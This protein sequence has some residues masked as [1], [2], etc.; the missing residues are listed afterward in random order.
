[1]STDHDPD[2]LISHPIADLLKIERREQLVPNLFFAKGVTTIVAPSG[3]GKTTTVFSAG[4]YAAIGLWG[5]ELI[6]K[7]PLFWIAGEDQAGLRAIYEA[8]VAHNPNRHPDARFMEEAVDFSNKTEVNKLIKHLDGTTRPLIVADALADILGDLNED[9]SQDINRV[10]RNVWRVVHAHDASFGLLHHSGWEEKRERGSTAIRAK[11]DIL[12]QIVSFDPEK[13]LVELKHHKLRG[14]APLKQFYLSVKLVP[15]GG[16]PQPIPIVTGP[17]SELEVILSEP[18]DADDRNAR[19]LVEIMLVGHF[20]EGATFTKLHKQSEM[21]KTTF[22]SALEC[23]KA[24]GWIVG[25]GKRGA[26]YNLNPDGSWKI[27]A[28]RSAQ[29]SDLV[30]PSAIPLRD[31]GPTGPI[32]VGSAGRSSD[33]VRTNGPNT[34]CKNA[35]TTG[36][37]EKPNQIIETESSIAA[38]KASLEE[39]KKIL[40]K[41]IER[42]AA[43][44]DTTAQAALERSKGDSLLAMTS[45]AIQH[46]DKKRR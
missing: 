2:K 24:K 31:S 7:R 3:A 35:D 6:K 36:S 25:G 15:V 37:A 11:S 20:P 38:R 45:E 18:L 34:D 8:W 30:G 46:A 40:R 28:E 16:Y 27:S 12:V 23:A 9:K 19:K 32:N 43:A 39:T 41:I 22:C 26:R 10:Y 4:L 17:K 1:M 44:D 33:H 21:K 13:G 29:C 14:G 5:A 42:Q